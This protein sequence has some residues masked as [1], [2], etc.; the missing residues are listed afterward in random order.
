MGK[1]VKQ[2]GNTN[3]KQT[4]STQGFAKGVYWVQAIMQNG[5][6]QKSKLVIE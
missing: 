1:V 2:F 3:S 4:I 6:I 5:A